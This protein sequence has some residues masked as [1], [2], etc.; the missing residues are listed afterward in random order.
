[1]TAPEYN[2]LLNLGKYNFLF[3]ATDKK[4]LGIKYSTL[5]SSSSLNSSL[6]L[7]KEEKE[8][9][10]ETEEETYIE[11]TYKYSFEQALEEK[12]I[13]DFKICLYILVGTID[14]KKDR[15]LIPNERYAILANQLRLVGAEHTLAYTNKKKNI[16]EFKKYINYIAP[17]VKV[18]TLH[19][20]DDKYKFKIL[21]EFEETGG[22]LISCKKISEGLNIPRVNNI[23]F[24]DDKKSD[25]DIIQTLSRALRQYEGKEYAKLIVPCEYYDKT[26]DLDYVCNIVKKCRKISKT[27]K[28]EIMN[29]IDVGLDFE[30]IYKDIELKLLSNLE[31]RF[32][33]MCK[34]LEEFVEINGRVI[35]SREMFKNIRLGRWYYKHK[36]IRKEQLKERFKNNKIIFENLCKEKLIVLSDIEKKEILISFIKENNR[37]PIRSEIYKNIKMFSIL[38]YLDLNKEKSLKIYEN[39]PL[40][41]EY[42]NRKKRKSKVITEEQK[43]NL[44]ISYIKTYNCLPKHKEKFQG[45]NIGSILDTLNRNKEKNLILYNDVSLVSEYLNRKKKEIKIISDTEKRE[46]ILKYIKT[47][48]KLPKDKENFEGYNISSI[49]YHMHKSKNKQKYLDLFKDTPLIID[50]LNK[51]FKISKKPIII[52][53]IKKKELIIEFIDIYGRL[54]YAKEAYKDYILFRYLYRMRKSKNKQIYL[55]LFK[56]VPLAFNYLN[57]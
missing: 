48:N 34:L 42:L 14:E 13:C 55:D 26:I 56:D 22:I 54:P 49:L 4:S 46:I 10:E 33:Y 45:H 18:Y 20:K 6:N 39:N 29:E 19:T 31:F 50:Y 53:D 5:N 40:I 15:N 1:M 32:E 8:E 2:K 41:L 23:C 16:L 24:V 52:S 17:A 57:S 30:N 7:F 47:Y 11:P 9:N 38:C 12:I 43:K 51:E 37:L 44:L 28:I 3:T 27:A 35:T 36:H 21:K 25:I